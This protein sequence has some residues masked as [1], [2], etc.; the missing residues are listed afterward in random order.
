MEKKF[1]ALTAVHLLTQTITR[2][3]TERLYA[4]TASITSH[5]SVI[6]A[7]KESGVRT[8]TAMNTQLFVIIATITTTHAVKSVTA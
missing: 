3:L 7:A 1:T 8:H 2:S 4:P 6:A 5:L